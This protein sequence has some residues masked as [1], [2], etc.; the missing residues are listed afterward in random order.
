MSLGSIVS[1]VARCL[2]SPLLLPGRPAFFP[3]SCWPLPPPSQP[4]GG[5]P[6]SLFWQCVQRD[7]WRH[8]LVSLRFSCIVAGGHSRPSAT[9]CWLCC[10]LFLSDCSCDASLSSLRKSTHP[11]GTWRITRDC[12][13]P[14][15][16]S[17]DGKRPRTVPGWCGKALPGGYFAAPSISRGL[18]WP[19]E[20][21]NSAPRPE[22]SKIRC[23]KRE[24][25]PTL[26]HHLHLGV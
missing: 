16:P 10:L 24:P 7:W 2:T 19:H 9:V 17:P 8:L 14:H 15:L 13:A 23:T 21:K 22:K 6:L 26:R 12:T 4:Y 1:A 5:Q 18:Q 3:V 11:L 25:E 20:T